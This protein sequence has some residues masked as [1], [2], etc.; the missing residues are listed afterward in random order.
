GEP[1]GDEHARQQPTIGILEL[2]AGAYRAAADIDPIVERVN[3]TAIRRLAVPERQ[4]H[5]DHAFG[6]VA[7]GVA[8]NA[9]EVGLLVDLEVGVHL[10]VGDDRGQERGAGPRL[11]E[12]AERDLDTTDPAGDRGLDIG[13]VEI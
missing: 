3:V 8:A 7:G 1:D 12:I 9:A 10:G 2:G 5:R 11:H 13:V 4:L 6:R